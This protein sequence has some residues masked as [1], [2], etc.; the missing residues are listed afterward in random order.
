MTLNRMDALKLGPEILPSN[1]TEGGL[2]T[3]KYISS[4]A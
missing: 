3:C 2:S 1:V 4:H